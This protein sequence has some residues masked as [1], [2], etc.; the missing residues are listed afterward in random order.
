MKSIVCS[1]CK[2]IFE[3]IYEGQGDGCEC[4]LEMQFGP[5]YVA[6]QDPQPVNE[7][8]IQLPPFWVGYAADAHE[9]GQL[10]AGYGSRHDMCSFAFVDPETEEKLLFFDIMQQYCWVNQDTN[11]CDD[12]IDEMI[13][14]K[15]LKMTY[16]PAEHFEYCEPE[17]E[18]E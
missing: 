14:L 10:S 17:E 9:N 13:E 15:Q 1:R 2:S 5:K 11:V 4:I 8:E 18:E 6:P 12:C 3:A 16:D 7:D